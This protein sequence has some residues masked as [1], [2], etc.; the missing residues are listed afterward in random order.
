MSPRNAAISDK[1]QPLHRDRQA[2]V[3]VRQSTPHQIERHQESTRLQY[4]LVD[5]ALA[6]GWARE[7][8]VV[9]DEDQGRSGASTQGRLGFQR[10][11]A[12]VGLGHVGLVLGVE[13]SRL[14]RSCCDWHQ[15][16]EICALRGTLLGDSQGIYDPNC[17]NDRLLLGLKA[18]ISEAE[19]HLLK[20]R[21]DEGRRAKAQ[22]GELAVT[23]PRGYLRRPDGS[24]GLDPDEQVQTTIRL[25][26]SLFERYGTISAVLRHL[27]T[28]DIHL[29]DRVR[30]GLAKGELAWRRPNRPTLVDLLHNPC[31]A[32]VYVY[33]RRQ[34]QP[35]RQQPGQPNTGRRRGHDLENGVIVLRDRLPAYIS[36]ERYMAN[37]EQMAANRS[38]H[39]GIPRHGP[40]LLSG[41]LAC[42]RCGHRMFTHHN[43]NGRGLR[44]VCGAESACYGVPICQALA[45]DALDAHVTELVLR[46]L[47]PA[48][49]DTSLQLAEDLELER[50]DQHR[51]WRLRLERAHYEAD[52]ASRMYAAVEPENRLV[53]RT[54]ERQWEEALATEQRLTADYE[55]FQRRAPRRLT[56][57][58][59]DAIRRLAADIPALWRAPTTTVVERQELVR[60]VLERIVVTVA[61]TTEVVV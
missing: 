47:T 35:A 18:T 36:W 22:R 7:R 61:G 41:L 52:R 31:Y 38:D 29:P 43:H 21:M 34:V 15:L 14:A 37:L 32:G 6:L 13:M 4:A 3:Y 9:I 20:A 50:A 55:S 48:A 10:L 40:G 39:R 26:F 44:Y 54:L 19:L 8:V 12:E 30:V 49:L 23:L 25:V 42:G 2:I 45:G 60:L 59:Q 33:G 17:L 46:A 16:I 24:V 11:F 56:A 28:H 1:I 58:E 53:A 51:Q 57:A 5:H 27:V